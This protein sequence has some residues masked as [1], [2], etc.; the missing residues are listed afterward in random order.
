VLTLDPARLGRVTLS[1]QSEGGGA[2]V[3]TMRAVEPVTAT[4][5]ARLGDDITAMLRAEP[6]LAGGGAAD[7]RLDIGRAERV[8]E[9]RQSDMRPAE[10]SKAGLGRELAS[11]NGQS[12]QPQRGPGFVD[13]QTQE[14][15]RDAV[16]PDDQLDSAAPHPG[17]DRLRAR[18]A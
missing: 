11:D 3:L 15:R 13:P 7:L 14:W 16:N 6:A 5:L 9:G 8:A 2:P 17:R 12:R 4:L 18:L 1:W 10:G